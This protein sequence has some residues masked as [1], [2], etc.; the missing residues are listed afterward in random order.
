[1]NV[2]LIC[3][4]NLILEDVQLVNKELFLEDCC[5]LI[6]LCFAP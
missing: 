3:M 4:F 1:M 6:K 2:M 5:Y